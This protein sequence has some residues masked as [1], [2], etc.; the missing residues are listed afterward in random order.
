MEL[1]GILYEAEVAMQIWEAP[2]GVEAAMQVLEGLYEVGAAMQVWEAPCVV[3]AAMQVWEALYAEMVVMPVW[4]VL[5]PEEGT[6]LEERKRETGEVLYG[7]AEVVSELE[8]PEERE[9]HQHLADVGLHSLLLIE[10]S[11]ACLITERG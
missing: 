7:P 10:I 8:C 9:L 1:W 5:Y 3:E 4:E 2:C 11:I 6:W